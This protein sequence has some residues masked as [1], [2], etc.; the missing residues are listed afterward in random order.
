MP[1]SPELAGI[2]PVILAPT[3]GTQADRTDDQAV[4][5]GPDFFPH[6]LARGGWVIC[7]KSTSRP[8]LST[9]LT[10]GLLCD[11]F[12]VVLFMSSMG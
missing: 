12:C 11:G 3:F 9:G 8:S 4:G 6:P 7:F 2:Q 10:R 1:K 5:A